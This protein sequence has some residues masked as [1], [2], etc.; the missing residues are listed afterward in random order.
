MSH[1][2]ITICFGSNVYHGRKNIFVST[3]QTLLLRD[4]VEKFRPLY[5]PYPFVLLIIESHRELNIFQDYSGWAITFH[6][7]SYREPESYPYSGR[8][9][10]SQVVKWKSIFSIQNTLYKIKSEFSKMMLHAIY[11][12]NSYRWW[13]MYFPIFLKP[14]R[15]CC[16]PA[17]CTHP[18]TLKQEPK[19]P[20]KLRL[21]S[22]NCLL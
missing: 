22:Q 13:I 14:R 17:T 1:Q 16:P 4:F 7:Y 2:S 10:L 12:D 19:A 21:T 5:L 8:L 3:T 15:C 6:G 18:T 9:R 20:S 11:I